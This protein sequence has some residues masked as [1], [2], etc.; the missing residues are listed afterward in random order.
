[1]KPQSHG[2]KYCLPLIWPIFLN[3]SGTLLQFLSRDVSISA[4]EAFVDVE[5]EPAGVRVEDVGLVA[6]FIL[7]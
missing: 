3:S 4:G 6:A 1:M 2:T 5:L 7:E